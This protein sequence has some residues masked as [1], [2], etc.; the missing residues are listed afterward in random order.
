MFPSG[1]INKLSSFTVCLLG[2]WL[3][4]SVP[5]AGAESCAPISGGQPALEQIDVEQRLQFIRDRMAHD[6]ALARTWSN[7]WTITWGLLT[8]GQLA[9]VA[10][11]DGD[12][13]ADLYVGA[14]SSFIGFAGQLI[15]PLSIKSDQ[16][17]LENHVKMVGRAAERC[18]LL[19]HAEKVFIENAENEADGAHWLMHGANVLINVGAML[20]LGLGYDRWDSG[21]I[22]A[23]A[24]IALGELMI[25]TQ[26]TGL[27]DDLERYRRGD[28]SQPDKAAW[29]WNLAPVI[30][31]NAYSL[32]LVVSF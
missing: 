10:F 14:G 16:T 12:A 3:V 1:R 26:P 20:I 21:A 23:A 32:Q 24:G 2:A 17:K 13:Q 6:A 22:N 18:K 5:T 4:M 19:E 8:G 7:A 28:I 31:H 9:L 15:L 11:F 27:V 29:H 25:F 30:S